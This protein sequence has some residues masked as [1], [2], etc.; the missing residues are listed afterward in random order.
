[1]NSRMNVTHSMACRPN[2]RT[3][4]VLL[5]ICLIAVLLSSCAPVFLYRHADRL[6]LW[7]IDEYVDLTST[8]K[9]FVRDRLRALLAQHRSE[10]LPMYER[11]L[12]Q[13][14]ENSADGLDRQEID[15]AFSRYQE[16]RAD[17]FGR[18]VPDGAALL[19]SLTDEQ[20]RYLETRLQRDAEKAARLLHENTEARLSAR[21]SKTLDRLR[22]WFGPLSKAQQARIQEWSMAL[23]DM[24]TVRV[25]RHHD[26]QQD[27]LHLLT[28]TRDR[29]AIS[30]Y[31]NYWVLFPERTARS[32]YQPAID[33]MN[34][35]MK[36]MVLAVDRLI[37]T[38]Q[39]ARALTK[40]QHLIDDVH[41]LAAS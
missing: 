15:W 28:A 41:A 30:A 12:V 3:Q 4:A 27:F 14:K 17:L 35:S 5:S 10:A 16:L 26:R 22:D 11:F 40:L 23:P 13:I 7:K 33:D 1:M 36:D 37:T 20:V 21:A 6:A 19:S 9:G 24:A 18:I 34:A 31:L 25:D 29:Q 32:D 39:R 38:Q 8:Q 2:R